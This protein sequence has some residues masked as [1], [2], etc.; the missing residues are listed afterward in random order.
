MQL[1]N[2]QIQA[3]KNAL[4]CRGRRRGGGFVPRPK[5]HFDNRYGEVRAQG[6]MYV[7]DQI[8][9][10]NCTPGMQIPE[11][12]QRVHEI[13]YIVSGG[14]TLWVNDEKIS[15][16]P[17]M[18]VINRQGDR[19]KI[20]ACADEALR[21]FCL[22]FQFRDSFP[23]GEI[24]PVKHFFESPGPSVLMEAEDMQEAFISLFDEILIRD[25]LTDVML[26]SCMN[27]I[28]CK[29]YRSLT[30]PQRT[31]YHLSGKKGADENLIYEVVHY[32]DGHAQEPGLL[33]TI[34]REFC[35][36]YD[37][38]A[39]KFTAVMG[40]NMRNYYH[41]RRFEKACEYLRSGLSVTAVSEMMGYKSIHAFSNAFKK[42]VG[43]SPGEYLHQL[44]EHSRP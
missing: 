26:E 8:C 13:T 2:E 44:L 35:Y 34:S 20:L 22:G 11:H 40:E 21:Y 38:L 27:R 18:A 29:A 33:S 4:Q 19:H 37:Y 16:K 3:E 30:R 10:L 31:G 15:L 6:G 28:I 25:E 14:G 7:L 1:A 17:R 39:R 23:Q 5:Y 32:I 9:D 12:V 24:Q 42:R 36:C 41:I 43:I